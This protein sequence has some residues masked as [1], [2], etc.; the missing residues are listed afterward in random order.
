MRQPPPSLTVLLPGLLA[1]LRRR[2]A[3]RVPPPEAPGLAALTARSRIGHGPRR[4]WAAAALHWAGIP[5]EGE[6][7][8]GALRR[9]GLGQPDDGRV[10]MAAAP[11]HIHPDLR[12]AVLFEGP[13]LQVTEAEA[14][15]LCAA[16]DAYWESEGLHLEPTTAAH[17]HLRLPGSK[18]PETTPLE[19]V[20]GRDPFPGLPRGDQRAFW[21]R[22]INETQ[23]LFHGHPVNRERAATGRPTLNALW[24]WGAAP[25]PPAPSRPVHVTADDPFLWGLARLHPE[26]RAETLPRDPAA[27]LEA[28]G[29]GRHLLHLPALA[30]PADYEDAPAWE[31]ALRT[32]DS[33]WFG[34]LAEALRTGRLGASTLLDPEGLELEARP[35]RWRGVWGRRGWAARLTGGRS[36]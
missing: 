17:W 18:T 12:G 32:M 35:G 4:D 8:V 11:V 33:A 13:D 1:P 34:P 10:W 20:R 15:S 5:L 22:V 23:M 19:V 28:L 36:A 25:L 9:L 2:A 14:R 6:P 16:F 21:W 26:G 24:L 31:E 27:W 30:R 3:A 29:P 7:P